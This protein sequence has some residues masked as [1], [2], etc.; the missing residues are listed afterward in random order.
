MSMSSYIANLRAKI[1]HDLLVV[2]SATA[3]LRDARGRVL[4]ARHADRGVWVPPGG[5]VDPGE[6]PADAAARETW[7]EVGLV[8]E[9]VRVFGVYGGAGYE[10][11]YG[12]GDRAAYVMTA[13]ECRIVG[14][15]LRPDGEEVLE[16][17][18]F[19]PEEVRGLP[20]PQW[21]REIFDDAAPEGRAR[22]EPSRW[23]PGSAGS[24]GSRGG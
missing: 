11:L 3:I 8:V 13:F 19:G 17:G 14:G 21:V 16:A 6:S 4:L 7:E 9:P 22:F 1:G 5:A 23:A 20:A 12:N 24:S 15:A 2:P 10:I 18:W